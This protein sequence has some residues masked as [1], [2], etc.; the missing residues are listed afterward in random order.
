MFIISRENKIF[1]VKEKYDT[2]AFISECCGFKE[3]PYAWDIR[4]LEKADKQLELFSS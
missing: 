1:T 4:W 2:N 3:I